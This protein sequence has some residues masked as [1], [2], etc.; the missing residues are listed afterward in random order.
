MGWKSEVGDVDVAGFL[1]GDVDQ[2]TL[3]AHK[4]SEPGKL[5]FPA[6]KSI[7]LKNQKQA[8]DFPL[9][10]FS[11]AKTEFSPSSLNLAEGGRFELPLQV[12]PD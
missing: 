8:S 6:V 4:F 3:R 5:R 11:P 10:Y 2:P 7:K 9:L 12:S 1:A